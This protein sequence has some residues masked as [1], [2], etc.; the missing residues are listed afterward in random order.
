MLYLIYSTSICICT[1]NVQQLFSQESLWHDLYRTCHTNPSIQLQHP[2]PNCRIKVGC[3]RIQHIR[4]TMNT[5]CIQWTN[6]SKIDCPPQ[7]KTKRTTEFGHKNPRPLENKNTWRQKYR[8]Q[9]AA[10]R[11]FNFL[12]KIGSSAQVP[13]L[14]K[15]LATFSHTH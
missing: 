9:Q 12:S 10:C 8:T 14:I 2:C 6:M 5:Q 4:I 7:K 15:C 1:N 13:I 11:N 3:M